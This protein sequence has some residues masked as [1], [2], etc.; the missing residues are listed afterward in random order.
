MTLVKYQQIDDHFAELP[1]R[2]LKGMLVDAR[3]FKAL[4]VLVRAHLSVYSNI[5]TIY[6]AKGAKLCD[7]A[8]VMA[9]FLLMRLISEVTADAA[10]EAQCLS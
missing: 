7:R 1:N 5:K 8:D 2:V 3:A 4:K 10:L 6:D 9:L